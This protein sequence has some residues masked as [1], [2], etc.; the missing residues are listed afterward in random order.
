M[1]KCPFM[2]PVPIEPIK[3][4]LSFASNYTMSDSLPSYKPGVNKIHLLS[5]KLGDTCTCFNNKTYNLAVS[6]STHLK[7]MK[8][9]AEP[10]LN[11][12][13]ELSCGDKNIIV[14]GFPQDVWMPIGDMK[15]SKYQKS[16]SFVLH[17]TFNI[18][19]YALC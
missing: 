7:F 11:V 1:E 10:L 16:E 2:N 3:Y 5:H 13:Y 4:T 8:V 14:S 12:S 19:I 18:Y 9:R 17:S 6:A 15:I